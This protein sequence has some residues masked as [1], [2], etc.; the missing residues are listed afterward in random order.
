MVGDGQGGERRAPWVPANP[1][2]PPPGMPP[3][4]PPAMPPI[5]AQWPGTQTFPAATGQQPPWSAPVPGFPA[6]G[7]P[8]PSGRGRVLLWAGLGLGVLAVVGAGTWLVLELL[9]GDGGAPTPATSAAGTSASADA[10]AGA[11]ASS[12]ADADPTQEAPEPEGPA[13]PLQPVGATA[14]CEAPP[15]VDAADNAVLFTADMAIDGVTT[16]AWRCEGAAQGQRIVFDFGRPVT[17]ESV[18]LVPGYAK[19][20][21]ADGTN[22]FTQNHTVTGVLW[23]FDDATA[24]QQVIADPR[25]A[26]DFAQPGEP[27]VTTQV[28]LEITSTGNP[29]AE[30]SFTPVSEVSFTGW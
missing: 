29:D 19:V 11:G 3:P 13:G 5:A 16:T 30:R 6:A 26:F 14:S 23:S 4:V 28:V 18:G 22:R 17:I 15:G 24:L 21:P 25:P 2:P 10:G 27:V 7:P 20:D 1:G 12:D 9:L 8:E